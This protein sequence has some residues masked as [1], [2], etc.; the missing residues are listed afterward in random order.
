MKLGSLL[1]L[2]MLAV[3]ALGCRGR[4]T[5]VG[6]QAREMGRPDAAWGLERA[7]RGVPTPRLAARG[8]V[9]R[10]P[11]EAQGLVDLNFHQ[12]PIH[13]V[14]L[15]MMNKFGCRV[16][17]TQPASRLIHVKDLRLTARASNVPANL[18]FEVLRGQLETK[19]LTVQEAP[20]AAWIGQA[21]FLID[22]SGVQEALL[23]SAR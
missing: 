19:G 15:V 23:P 12:T 22:R 1:P 11:L 9:A 13:E 5:N 2:A 10:D 4:G 8:L 18:A 14:I 3:L 6:F 20:N 17:L 7:C 16:T 21:H